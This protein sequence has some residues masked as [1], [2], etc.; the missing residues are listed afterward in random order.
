M[1]ILQAKANTA[2]RAAPLQKIQKQSVSDDVEQQ[3]IKCRVIAGGSS[4]G[5][6]TGRQSGIGAAGEVPTRSGG[7]VRVR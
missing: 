3:L 1:E 2:K 4:I 7:P 6:P 5:K